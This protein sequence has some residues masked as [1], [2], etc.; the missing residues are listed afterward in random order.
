[1]LPELS[2]PAVWSEDDA[3]ARPGRVE[4][5]GKRLRLVGGSR[6]AEQTREL[7]LSEISSTRV[8]RTTADR[9][10]GRPTLVLELRR[11]GSIRIAG[12]ARLGA[13][14]ELTERLLAAT[15]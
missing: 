8:G 13:L 10:G 1:M 2:L 12:F 7:E 9:I 3:P 6:E 11:G 4:L 14:G 15:T 5:R